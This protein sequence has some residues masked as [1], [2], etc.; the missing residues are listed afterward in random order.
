MR[1]RVGSGL[2]LDPQFIRV[3]PRYSRANQASE[4]KV[5]PIA[6]KVVAQGICACP[7]VFLG[8]LDF[9]MAGTVSRLFGHGRHGRHGF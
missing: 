2:E 7:R 9:S 3:D 5:K 1:A 4:D 6:S 8:V